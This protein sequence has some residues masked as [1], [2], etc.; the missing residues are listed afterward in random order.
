LF[1]IPF[2]F[3]CFVLIDLVISRNKKLD[4]T[5]RKYIIIIILGEI[6]SS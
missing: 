4:Y 3:D 6:T 1:E 2:D 5:F